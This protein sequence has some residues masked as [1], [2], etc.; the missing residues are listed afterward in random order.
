MNRKHGAVLE[1]TD[2][3]PAPQGRKVGIPYDLRRPTLSKLRSRWW[4]PADARVFTPK[5]FGMGWD[6][7]LYRLA[8]PARRDDG[9]GSND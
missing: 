5:T 3:V 7:N 8:H 1:G 2:A 6:I 4:N 9:K